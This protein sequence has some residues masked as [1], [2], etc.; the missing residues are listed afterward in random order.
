MQKQPKGTPLELCIQTGAEDTVDINSSFTIRALHRK[1]FLWLTDS[2]FPLS[3]RIIRTTKLYL[4]ACILKRPV[5][6]GIFYTGGPRVDF[7]CK[8]LSGICPVLNFNS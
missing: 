3:L 1:L 5:Y 4:A 7:K 2:L 8:P 6:R